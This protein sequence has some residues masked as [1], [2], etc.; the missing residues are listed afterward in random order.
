M[1]NQLKVA[2]EP[3]EG[4]K[5]TKKIWRFNVDFAAEYTKI[6]R[7]RECLFPH[8]QKKGV[9]WQEYGLDATFL[10]MYGIL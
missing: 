6:K 9:G 4:E 3:H 8:I 2:V 10:D 5:S 1:E 7:N